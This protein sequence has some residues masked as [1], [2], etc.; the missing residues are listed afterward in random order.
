MQYWNVHLHCNDQYYSQIYIKRGI[1]Q[2]D[3]LSP[4]LIIMALMPLSSILNNTKKGFVLEKD[5]LQLNYI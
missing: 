3:S 2:G 1:Y 4:L 5:G